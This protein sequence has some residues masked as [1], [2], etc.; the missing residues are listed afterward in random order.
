MTLI[1]SNQ[2]VSWN[3][4]LQ[5]GCHRSF[6][7]N[8]Y[9]GRPW[10][11]YSARLDAAF[12]IPCLLFTPPPKR[13]TL[14]ALI[15]TPYRRWARYSQVLGPHHSK[16]Y[17]IEAQLTAN[18]FISTIEKPQGKISNMLQSKRLENISNNRKLLKHIVSAVMFLGKQGL[19]FR[20][21]DETSN[22]SNRGNFLELL[23]LLSDYDPDLKEH[24]E[25]N[26]TNANYMSPCSQN[27]M[28]SVIGHDIIRAPIINAIKES[29]F[30]SILCDEASSGTTEYLSLC[31]RFLDS[32]NT[33]QEQ[34]LCFHPVGKCSGQ[35][36]GEQILRNVER[37][38]LEI[39][40][41]R[42]QGYDGA[43][44]MSSQRCG[45]QSVVREQAPAAAYVHCA[46]HCL[47]LVIVHACEIVAVKNVITKI[48]AVSNIMVPCIYRLLV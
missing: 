26:R 39:A 2:S 30:Y 17:H 28:I 27:E 6:R 3:F 16:K 14:E 8:Y 20:G 34:F 32:S 38:G 40:D 41:C 22:S 45:V 10:L 13:Y 29:K 48:S 15:N 24:L 35:L 31:V 44:V 5:D 11:A 7:S 43:A 25:G 19:A 33:I 9:T 12:C 42:G 4:L 23:H 1:T 46:S 18:A 47:N 21:H 37:L 36:L